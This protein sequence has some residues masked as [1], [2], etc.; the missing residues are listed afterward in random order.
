MATK[1][2]CFTGHRDIPNDKL[3]YIM[4]DLKKEIL[5]AIEEGFTHFIC[6]FA[7]GADLLFASIV[8]ELKAEYDIRLEAAIPYRGRMDTP[9]K[10]F[11]ELIKHCDVIGI[12]SEQYYSGC[13]M[14]R[15]RFMVDHSERVIAV[16]DGRETGGTAWTVRYARGNKIKAI[17]VIV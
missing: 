10:T 6:G 4:A 8:V 14:K 1:T 9:D 16:Y 13:Y 15:N 17:H 2:C 12:H 3:D 7:E 11:Q 5:T